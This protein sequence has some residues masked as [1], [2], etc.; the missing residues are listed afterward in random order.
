[1]QFNKTLLNYIN[2]FEKLSSGSLELNTLKSHC[3]DIIK[4]C[5]NTNTDLTNLTFSNT[6]I[7]VNVFPK[8]NDLPP[9]HYGIELIF[10]KDINY[11]YRFE[12]TVDGDLSILFKCVPIDSKTI[13]KQCM[14][15]K[16]PITF[17]HGNKQITADSNNS[18][19]FTSKMQKGGPKISVKSMNIEAKDGYPLHSDNKLMLI[20]DYNR[21][22][23]L[24]D[25]SDK[26]KGIFAFV[27]TSPNYGVDITCALFYKDTLTMYIWDVYNFDDPACLAVR[28]VN[29]NNEHCGNNRCFD[30]QYYLDNDSV[31]RQIIFND[32]SI[33][34]LHSLWNHPYNNNSGW[35]NLNCSKEFSDLKKYIEFSLKNNIEVP[36]AIY[37]YELSQQAS[38]EYD[39]GSYKTSSELYKQIIDHEINA[40]D[41]Y[42]MALYDYS[43]CLLKLSQQEKQN[44]LIKEQLKEEAIMTL[45]KLKEE[46]YNDWMI[47]TGDKDFS[48][49]QQD[50]RIISMVESMK[51]K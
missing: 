35:V 21:Y 6:K 40:G 32:K 24:P 50:E 20:S 7:L 15:K 14:L 10:D 48:A 45:L 25:F 30:V 39:K 8:N 42:T 47:I 2:S 43:C 4:Q 51:G 16:F 36:F 23:Y 49:I 12:L 18:L 33:K 31:D 1:M 13:E 9:T 38:Q 3:L 11:C 28:K 29:E 34:R 44:E 27:L 22:I 17:D 46:D 26:V 37:F 19:F 5:D 41:Y